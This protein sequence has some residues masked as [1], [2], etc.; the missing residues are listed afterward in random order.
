VVSPSCNV[1]PEEMPVADIIRNLPHPAL[2]RARISSGSRGIAYVDGKETFQEKYNAI[3]KE[4][5]EPIVQ[6]YIRKKSYCS[7][8]I[9][10]DEQSREVA[11]FTY[12]KVKEYP[13]SGGQRSLAT[14]PIIRSKGLCRE[15][16]PGG[17]LEG[18]AEAD[19][20]IDQQGIPVLLEINPRFWMPLNLAIKS[21]VDF[22]YLLYQLAQGQKIA[23]Q[24][25]YTIGYK[26]RWVLPNE[27]LWLFST[28]DKIQGLKEFSISGREIS[29]METCRSMI[30]CRSL[31]YLPRVSIS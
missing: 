21:G 18:V 24:Q 26:Y 8:C 25:P 12:E 7:A 15:T 4:Y 11:S 1:F 9:L 28:P 10:L 27:V 13:L 31:V 6:E 19:F 5:G 2:V 14:A 17:W 20:M 23:P 30:R 3:K 16:S 29:V 22:P